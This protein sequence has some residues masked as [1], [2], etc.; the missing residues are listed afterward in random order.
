MLRIQATS[1]V[2]NQAKARQ[3]QLVDDKLVSREVQAG[4]N[5]SFNGC[6]TISITFPDDIYK[7]E[8]PQ[9]VRQTVQSWLQEIANMIASGVVLGDLFSP[10]MGSIIIAGKR[11]ILRYVTKGLSEIGGQNETK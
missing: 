6:V 7:K 3:D 1:K 4:Y 11:E 9:D 8:M 10:L 5:N 2:T